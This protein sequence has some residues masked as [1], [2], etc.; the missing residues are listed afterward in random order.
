MEGD[1]DRCIAA[2]MD[3][4]LCKPIEVEA[5]K[6]MV[7]KWSHKAETPVSEPPPADAAS[8]GESPPQNEAKETQTHKE[9]C[10]TQKAKPQGTEEAT[11]PPSTHPPMAASAP[12]GNSVSPPPC[13]LSPLRP[14][15]VDKALLLMGGD[16]DLFSE[17]LAAFVD[18]VPHLLSR[19][20]TAARAGDAR[21]LHTT[22]HGLKGGASAVAAEPIRSLAERIEGLGRTGDVSAAAEAIRQLEAEV[23]RL[24]ELVTSMNAQEQSNNEP[25]IQNTRG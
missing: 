12:P 10:G 19:L 9:T 23:A 15:D 14:L 7:D 21:Q 25:T 13:V 16:R 3:D 20:Q 11:A 2:G 18:N 4:Y 22:A 8:T 1:R 17:V 6:S 5:L 24:Q